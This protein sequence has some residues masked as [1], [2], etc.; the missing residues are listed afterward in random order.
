MPYYY[1]TTYFVLKSG[2]FF[3]SEQIIRADIKPCRNQFHGI[4]GRLNSTV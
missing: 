1:F 2:L 4:C 3:Y